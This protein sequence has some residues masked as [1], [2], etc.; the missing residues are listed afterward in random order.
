MA[1]TKI[2]SESLNLADDFAFTGTITGAG[3]N[4]TPNFRVKGS[5]GQIISDATVTKVIYNTV[6]FDTN[7]AFDTNNYRFVVPSGHAGKYNFYSR[8]RY[9][10]VNCSELAF[11]FY[12]NGAVVSNQ[13]YYSG[14]LGINLYSSLNYYTYV[15]TYSDILSV[16]DY[17]EIFAY[18]NNSSTGQH[19]IQTHNET[20]EFVG[21]KI[22]E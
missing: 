18:F 21:Y 13:Y 14:S 12:K 1:I 7:S 19:S 16:G 17:I 10:G 22:I 11:Y 4:N 15:V 3:G 6:T 2:Q 20:G 8:F 5:G 9:G